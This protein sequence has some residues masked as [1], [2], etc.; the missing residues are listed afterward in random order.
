LVFSVGKEEQAVEE[1]R[2][3]EVAMARNLMQLDAS[4]KRVQWTLH[5]IEC[6]K[7]QLP[8]GKPVHVVIAEML[9]NEVFSYVDIESDGSLQGEAW[10]T[11]ITAKEL[12]CN[13]GYSSLDHKDS[14]IL[15]QA[16][17]YRKTKPPKLGGGTVD[18]RRSTPGDAVI[19]ID[20]SYSKEDIK[21]D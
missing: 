9:V 10:V 4:L 5:Y 1:G 6:S 12:P 15:N 14:Y 2:G 18:T 20:F 7:A 16:L 8:S 13:H 21:G 3:E 19:K 11:D 17:Y